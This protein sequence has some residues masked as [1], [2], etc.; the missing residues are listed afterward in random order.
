M[1]MVEGNMVTLKSINTELH[2]SQAELKSKNKALQDLLS[3][4]QKNNRE[5]EEKWLQKEHTMEEDIK[6][7]SELNT[8]LQELADKTDDE[9]AKMRKNEKRARKETEK[10]LKK[11]RKE[12]EKREKKE[13][14]ENEKKE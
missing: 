9:K 3:G 5:L 14:K 8:E 10:R 2:Q 4:E 13:K 11:E 6:L 7:L 1:A 12:E